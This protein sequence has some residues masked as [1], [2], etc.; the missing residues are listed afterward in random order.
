MDRTRETLPKLCLPEFNKVKKNF[1]N[2]DQKNVREREKQQKEMKRIT[3]IA[4]LNN[5]DQNKGEVLPSDKNLSLL[6]NL[7][8]KE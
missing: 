2:N 4:Q 1:I 5:L 3:T 6:Q 7:L 8:Q